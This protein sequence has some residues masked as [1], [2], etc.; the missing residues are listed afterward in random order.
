MTIYVQYRRPKSKGVLNARN[1]Q[2]AVTEERWGWTR[3]LGINVKIFI[4]CSSVPT[5]VF[6]AVAIG[7]VDIYFHEVGC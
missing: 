3:Y 4:C 7:F 1:A 5:F 6:W 2:S